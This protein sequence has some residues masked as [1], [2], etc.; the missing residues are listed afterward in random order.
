MG[1]NYIFRYIDKGIYYYQYL[2]DGYTRRFNE[3]MKNNPKGL[4]LYYRYMLKKKIPIKN[5][6]KFLIRFFQVLYYDW[7]REEEN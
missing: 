4:K 2:N 6:I 7:K 1:E 5:K 3:I